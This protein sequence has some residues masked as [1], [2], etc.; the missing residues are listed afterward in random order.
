MSLLE[1]QSLYREGRLLPFVGAGIS[2]SVEWTDGT[3]PYRGPTWDDMVR[4]AAKELGFDPPEL[5]R[6]RGTDLQ[7]L[8]FYKL[9]FSGYS[10]LTNWLLLHMNP[11]DSALRSSLIHNEL[12]QMVK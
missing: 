12:V 7:I 3:V 1:L 2:A 9:H 6:A 5:L 11:P 4:Q 10:R 8:E